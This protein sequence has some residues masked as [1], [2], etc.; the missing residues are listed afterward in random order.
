MEEDNRLTLVPKIISLDFK[1]K[2]EQLEKNEK[3]LAFFLSKACWDVA[4]I[5]LFQNSYESPA[6]FLILQK[7]FTSFIPFENLKKKVF[8]K[9]K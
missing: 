4:P 1:T 6:V 2:F 7:F 3:Y 8:E 9:G 5:L